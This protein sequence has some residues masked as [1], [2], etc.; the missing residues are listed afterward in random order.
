[1]RAARVSE[2][3]RACLARL[4]SEVRDDP[5]GGG[6]GA[7]SVLGV[8]VAPDLSR[9]RVALSPFGGGIGASAAGEALRARWSRLRP[10]FD[11][12]MGLRRALRVDFVFVAAPEAAPEA[13]PEALPEAA[14]A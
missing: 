14:T 4:L 12:A 11:R 3:A 2:R 10:T 9:A 8:D 1:M 7:W 6:V 5:A 13:L